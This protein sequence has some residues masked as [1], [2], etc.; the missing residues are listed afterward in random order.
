MFLDSLA[1]HHLRF[2]C[3]AI[4]IL[5]FG[6]QAGAQ[7]RGAL[8]ESL[9]PMIGDTELFQ[10]FMQAETPDAAR[11]NNPARPF[12]IRPPLADTPS[13]DQRYDRGDQFTFAISLFGTMIEVFPY[14][15]QAIYHMGQT[16]VGYGRGQF[17]LEAV[18]AFNPLTGAEQ[19]LL[20][21]RRIIGLPTIPV[22][23]AQV[24]DVAQTLPQHNL[25]L[26]FIT[27]TQLTGS[28]KQLLPQPIFDR[29]I[30][31]LIERCQMIAENYAAV[32]TPQSEWRDLYLNLT[33]SA[34]AIEI[35]SCHTHWVNVRSGSR[36]VNTSKKISGFVGDVSY[37]GPLSPFL[38]WIL[39]GQSLQVGKNTVKGD[40]WYELI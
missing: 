30:A 14:L 35:T 40:G 13:I 27:P 12:S 20:Q 31:R 7:I 10:A 1:V 22:T 26:K 19:S 24:A 3:T 2:T 34:L 4:S 18:E 21:D 17:I 39:W 32:S 6:P 5:H 11:G 15:V 29:L 36:R 9:K 23:A 38:S 25:S 8:W 33:S 16:G 28:N 37:Q